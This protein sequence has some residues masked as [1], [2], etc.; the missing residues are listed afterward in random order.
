MNSAR[1]AALVI[2][3]EVLFAVSFGIAGATGMAG[4]ANASTFHEAPSIVCTTDTRVCLPQC[5]NE[6]GN[7]DGLPCLWVDPDSGNAYL[8]DSANY[9]GATSSAARVGG[10][11]R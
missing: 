8:N 6:D 11:L 7:T 2:G 10:A 9:R 4:H 3:T 5:A 1:I